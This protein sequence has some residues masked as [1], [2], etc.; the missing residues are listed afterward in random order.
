MLVAYATVISLMAFRSAFVYFRFFLNTS[1]EILSLYKTQDW[2][3]I[4][5]LLAV[6]QLT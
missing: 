3:S 1:F 5:T 6:L 4:S 2:L